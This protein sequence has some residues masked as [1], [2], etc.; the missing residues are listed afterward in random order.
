[1]SVYCVSYDL[2][3][4]G[5]SYQP[6]YDE[7][8]R[9]PFWCHPLDS[10]WMISTNESAQALT[11]RLLPKIDQNDRLLV[12]AVGRERQGWLPKEVWDWFNSHS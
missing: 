10:T 8:K 5:Q 1:M 2:N 4:P 3:R 6:L 7:L 9:S 11:G 12:I